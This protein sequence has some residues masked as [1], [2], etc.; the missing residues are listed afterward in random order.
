MESQ[1][2]FASRDDIWR[3]QESLNEIATIQGQHTERI[4]RLEKRRDDD[5]RVKSVW[6]S[7]SPYP[8]GI[9]G[10]GPQGKRS[11]SMYL[12][13]G[14]ILT[15]PTDST[16]NPAAEAFRNFDAD[17][18]P[19]LTSSFSLD[20][21]ED[22]RRG[23]AS[24]ANSVR[25]DESANN[26][27]GSTPRQSIE[28]PPRTGSGLGSHPLSERSLSHRS[29]GRGSSVGLSHR[30]NSFG[31]EQSR[32]LA[33]IN[34]S[35]RVSGNPPPG[36]FVLGPCPSIIRCWLTETFSHD[37]LLYAAVCTGSCSS[38]VGT[39]MIQSLGLGD[40]MIEENGIRKIKLPVYLTEAKI[41]QASSRS[42][43]PAPQVPTLTAKFTVTESSVHDKS[44]QIVLGSDVL[45]A[46]NAD[47]L[48]SQDKL[49]I[50]DEDRNQLAVPLV[51]PE[52]DAV[53]KYLVTSSIDSRV[54]TNPGFPTLSPS[55]GGDVRTPGVIGQPARL[56]AQQVATSPMTDSP[57]TIASGAQ[58]EILEF[59]KPDQDISG[60]ARSSSDQ[61]RQTDDA[62][63]ATSSEKSFHTPTPKL[64][65]GVWGSSW[66]ANSTNS[67]S[68]P[69]QASKTASGYSKAGVQRNMKVLRPSGKSMSNA[70]RTSSSTAVANGVENQP[71]PHA[72][73]ARRASHTSVGEVKLSA[74]TKSNPVGQA[75]AFPWLNSGQSKRALA[76]GD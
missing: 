16:L 73:A 32:L 24:R 50:F 31:I 19:G 28:L 14:P 2:S 68:D 61:P 41:H 10:A 70:S 15:I 17:P 52:N 47:I 49:M 58:S 72:D 36:F 18:L 69:S 40:Q 12:E 5:A 53:Y 3:L 22:R 21:D 29:D 9:G 4:M 23:A 34:N 54:G 11:L 45:R 59:H 7:T 74:P 42:A 60:T 27:Y 56:V 44:I 64:N 26:H 35:P 6:G 75:S 39:S 67:S 25:F 33:S 46:H 13:G 63:S 57:S 8:V 20:N 66:R 55:A 76:N 1:L 51:R 43:S 48:L 71:Q 37:S 38:T 62:K 30:T 65:S